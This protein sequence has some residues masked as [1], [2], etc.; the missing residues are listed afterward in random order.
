VLEG[1]SASFVAFLSGG[2]ECIHKCYD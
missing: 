1:Y 2:I